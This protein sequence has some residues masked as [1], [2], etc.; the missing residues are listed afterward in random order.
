M[1][2]TGGMQ[3]PKQLPLRFGEEWSV[4]VLA[5]LSDK[6]KDEALDTLKEM[7]LAAFEATRKGGKIN[8]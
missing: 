7:L 1:S 4:K 2:E 3:M 5:S 8:G 6:E